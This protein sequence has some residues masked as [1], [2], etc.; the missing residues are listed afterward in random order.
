[1]DDITK[2]LTQQEILIE[3]R[4]RMAPVAWDFL[5][6]GG[7]SE[8]TLKRN[9]FSLDSIAFR[10]R[11]LISVPD[12]DPAVTFMGQKIRIPVICAPVGSLHLMDPGGNLSVVHAMDR[13]GSM[14]AISI[15]S[16]PRLEDCAAETKGTKIFQLYVRGDMD[17]TK[18]ILDRVVNAGFN[19]LVITVDTAH[20]GRRERDQYNRFLRRATVER[21]NLDNVDPDAEWKYRGTLTWDFIAACQEHCG[22]P[23][24]VKGIATAEDAKIALERKVDVIWVSNHGGR[25]MDHGRGAIA[26]LPEVAAVAKGKVPIVI[27]S[28]FLRG[29]DVLKAIALGAD[30]VAVGKLQG[31]ALAAGGEDGLLRSFEILENEIKTNMGLLGVNS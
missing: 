28:G 30:V 1:M 29:T 7:E 14:A 21:A 15:M 10:P 11:V 3:A 27:D 24:M 12:P 23:V 9:R 4:K 16:N 5:S 20:Y 26:C 25:Q 17:W 2:A 18:R 31:W 6:G 19:A 22:L 8:T 13:F